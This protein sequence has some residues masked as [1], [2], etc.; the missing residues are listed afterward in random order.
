MAKFGLGKSV[1]KQGGVAK[2][3]VAPSKGGKTTG[4]GPSSKTP[5]LSPDASK[6]NVRPKPQGGTGTTSAKPKPFK[7]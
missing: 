1:P 5:G 6:A 7:A 3:N 4:G 2:A